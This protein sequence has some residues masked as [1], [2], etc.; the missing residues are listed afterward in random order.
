MQLDLMDK[1]LDWEELADKDDKSL[2][3][4][5][6]MM[7][8]LPPDHVLNNED[9]DLIERFS[10]VD[11]G[12]GTYYGDDSDTIVLECGR[13]D[14]EGYEGAWPRRRAGRP[15]LRPRSVKGHPRRPSAIPCCTRSAI[16][17]TTRP[18]G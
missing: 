18:N 2:K 16:P 3:H 9:L 13:L 10:E 6:Q 12:S 14:A 4:I 17:S 11:K 5:Y 7:A 8:K 1:E 15:G